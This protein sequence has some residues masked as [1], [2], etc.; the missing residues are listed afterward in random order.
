MYRLNNLAT[1]E[2]HPEMTKRYPI[3]A[4]I[5]GIPII[6]KDDE[7]Q[8]KDNEVASTYEE[9]NYCYITENGEE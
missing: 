3:F 8:N 9:E 6:D 1:K 7:S 4:W 5:P 2:K